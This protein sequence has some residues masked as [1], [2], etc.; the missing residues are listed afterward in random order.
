LAALAMVSISLRENCKSS[1]TS[2]SLGTRP[3]AVQGSFL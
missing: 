1:S 2:L 3:F